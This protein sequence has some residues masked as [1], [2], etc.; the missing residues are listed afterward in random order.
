MRFPLFQFTILCFILSIAACSDS[1]TSN[2]FV[3]DPDFIAVFIENTGPGDLVIS[4]ITSD[5]CYDEAGCIF[6]N[7]EIQSLSIE[8][9]SEVEISISDPTRNAVGVIFSFQASTGSGVAEARKGS[10]ERD[11]GNYIFESEEV[12]ESVAFHGGQ[13]VNIEAGE[14]D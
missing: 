5:Y 10:A 4:N 12:M 9:G 8:P 13:T 11:G 14:T 3:E 1:S 7:N 2:D 6:G